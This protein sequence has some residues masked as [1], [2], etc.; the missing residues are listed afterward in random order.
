M[1]ENE[2]ELAR[3]GMGSLSCLR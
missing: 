1:A 3:S 2:N